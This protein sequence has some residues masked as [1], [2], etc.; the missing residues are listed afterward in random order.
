MKYLII[1][2]VAGGATTAAR[3][4]R[5]DETSEI[6]MFERGEYISYANCGLPYYIGSVIS[7]RD[8]LFVQTPASFGNRFNIKV[9]NLNEVQSINRSEKIIT[10]KDISTGNIYTESYDKLVLSPGAE[11]I[12]PPL[13]G[14]NQEGIFTLRSVPDTDKIKQFIVDKKPKH[15]V[16][17]GAGFIGLEMAENLHHQGI[18]VTII[19]MAEQVMGPI[20]YSMAALVHQH[21]KTKNVEFYLNT[22]VSSFSKS[23]NRIIVTLNSTRTIETDMVVLSIGVRPDSHLAK[24]AGLQT[25]KTGGIIVNEYLQTSDKDIYAVGDAIEFVNP[26]TGTRM[27]T[28]LAGPANKQGRIAADNIVMGNKKVYRGSVNTAIAKVFDVT[29]A[30]AGASGKLLGKLNIPHIDSITHSS[31]HAGYYPGA[32]PMS[33]KISFSPD[34]GRL[35]GAQIVGFSGVDKR[36]DLFSEAIRKGLTVYDLAEIEHSYAPP[37]S[38]AKDPVNIAGMVAE[39]ILDGIANM[40]SWREVSQD[41]E[42][43]LFLLDVRTRDEFQLGTIEGAV[44]IPLDELR[45]HLNLIPRNK[46]IV[47]FCGVGLRAHVACRILV[48]SGFSEVFNLSGGLKTYETAT[49]KQSNEDIFANDYIGHDDNIYQGN[50]ER[51][52]FVP[53]DKT[54]LK[55]V[56]ACGL[57]CPGPVL[58]LKK[59]VDE[60]A[61]GESVHIKA[62]DAG[63][64][65]DVKAWTNVT[66]NEL[67]ELT[68]NG[69]E[70]SAIVRKSESKQEQRVL[71]NG[72]NT[73]LICFSDDLDK[74]L[75]TFVI[76]NGAAS[77]GKK[78]T[79]FFTFWGLNV[80]KKQNRGPVKKDFFGKM[81]GLMLPSSSKKL[82]LSKMNMFGAGG[83]MMRMIM[84]KKHVDSLEGMIQSALSNGV[85]FIACQ[86]S[87]DVMG[88]KAEEFID[89][90]QIGGVATYLERTESANLNLFM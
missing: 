25:G 58:R 51:I 77:T 48:Q 55:E 68:Q 61:T 44:N 9:R 19:E 24:D 7:E 72:N 62:S 15:A 84:K 57:Q 31:S 69:A 76:A 88:V 75:A 11:P 6:I 54:K 89:G 60:I 17:I 63:F 49:Q 34:N 87:M 74:A 33:I 67:V 71:K 64:Y 5:L 38:S 3:L 40:I 16:V 2:G 23:N 8:K 50:K 12:R 21:L 26:V 73:T 43:K 13:P 47:V 70:I 28:Y 27:I 78:V 52:S 42:K 14:I 59:A 82:G 36:I 53:F 83:P 81:F 10:I 30:S 18:K 66:G 32:L 79:I 41:T 56:D 90:V 22:A 37:Y 1:G 85:E 45:L 80:I 86:M 4:R 20:D 46:K 29:V 65:K 39:N 35:L